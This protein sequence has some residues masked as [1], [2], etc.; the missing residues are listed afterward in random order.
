LSI[1]SKPII[2]IV[3][4][5]TSILK[6]FARIFDKKG[7]SV[8]VAENGEQAI[9]KLK[10]TCFDIALIDFGLPDIE[11][12]A[13]FSLIE[14]LSPRTVRILLTG[15]TF[16]EGQVECADAFIG[17]PVNPEKLLSVNDTALKLKDFEV[18]ETA[19]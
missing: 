12:I 13:L 7:F 16:L 9:E 1:T 15:K 5:D 17:K 4:D 19:D 3:D 11:G 2:L 8:T 14:K 10:T 18:E 6:T